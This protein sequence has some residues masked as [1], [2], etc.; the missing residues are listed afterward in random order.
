MARQEA[1]RIAIFGA[2]PIGLEAALYARS[3]HFP[4]VVYERGR[5]GEY[6]RRW[7]HVRLFSPF[8]MNSTPLGRAAIQAENAR[9]EFPQD[10][11]CT[12]GKQHLSSYLEPLA[13]TSALHDCIRLETQVLHVSRKG[14]LKEDAVD[15]ERRGQQPFRLLVREAKNRERIDEAD[16]VL[17]CSGTYGQHRWM[18]DGGIPAIGETAA[19]GFIA[20]GLDDVLSERRSAYAGKSILLIG[21]G[22][23]AATTICNLA[24]LAENHAETW[25]T[26]LARGSGTQPLRRI[27]N[28]PLRER[29]R[30]AARANTLATRAEGNV[31]FHNQTI[32]ETIDS[33]GPEKGFRVTTRSGGKS[34]TWE[35]ERLIANVGYSPDTAIYRELQIHESYASLGPMILASALKKNPVD[36]L[37]SLGSDAASL[38]NP[39]PNFFILGAKSFGRNSAFLLRNGFEQIREAFRVITGK[40]DTDLYKSARSQR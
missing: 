25:V 3:L 14:F 1:P 37:A 17:D 4:V 31:E 2:G 7:G 8:V 19:E 34:R 33:A 38:R 36:L 26:W 22:Y 39:E 28:D 10:S 16:I 13:R 29:D 9:Y 23:S 5:V 40:R 15:D 20:Y 11:D 27:A 35:V 21:S 32:V 30:L 12:T 6:L 24:A 18:G